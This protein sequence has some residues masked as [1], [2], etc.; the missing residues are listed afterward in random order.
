MECS[1]PCCLIC[2]SQWLSATMARLTGF[3]RDPDDPF[4]WRREP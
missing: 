3:D 4:W 2:F 1:Q